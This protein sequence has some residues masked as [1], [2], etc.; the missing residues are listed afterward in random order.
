MNGRVPTG[1][2][3]RHAHGHRNSVVAKAGHIRTC[4][5]ASACDGQPIFKFLDISAQEAQIGYHG[6]NA[7]TLLYTQLPCVA[8]YST[9]SC[10]GAGNGKNGDFVN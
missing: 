1:D 10:Q 7:V 4:K 6:M 2:Q 3:A 5:R 8:Y 9:A